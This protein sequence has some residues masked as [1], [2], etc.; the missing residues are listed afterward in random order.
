MP[1]QSGSPPAIFSLSLIIAALRY[2]V[3]LLL[4]GIVTLIGIVDVIATLVHWGG[5]T[6]G[7]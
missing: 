1:A 4:G 2:A 3:Q 7:R 5:A 6:S